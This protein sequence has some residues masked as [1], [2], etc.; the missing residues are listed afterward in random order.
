MRSV[1]FTSEVEDPA[2]TATKKCPCFSL[3]RYQATCPLQLLRLRAALPVSP[4]SQL[5]RWSTQGPPKDQSTPNS[6]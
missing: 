5:V 2:Q 1:L 4:T 3:D 6:P